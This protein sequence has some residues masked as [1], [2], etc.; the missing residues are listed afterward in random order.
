MA[1]WFIFSS[2]RKITF[3]G[4][5][6]S[7]PPHPST[8]PTSM[9]IQLKTGN[10]R[11]V[12]GFGFCNWEPGIR[13]SEPSL[14]ATISPKTA[15][16]SPKIFTFASR[17]YPHRFPF[18]LQYFTKRPDSRAKFSLFSGSHPSYS[19]SQ[20]FPASD[21]VLPRPNSPRS[22]C[23]RCR[24]SIILSPHRRHRHGARTR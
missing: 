8:K 20:H 9:A 10:E 1:S 17:G 6:M 5:T 24:M 7:N 13:N 2:Y 23:R 21:F 15:T 22:L 14:Q 18:K 3:L 11:R 19:R 16:C 12:L 4:K